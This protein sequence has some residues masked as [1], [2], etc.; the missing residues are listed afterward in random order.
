MS[1]V[2]RSNNE[3]NE[4]SWD[5]CTSD[6]L[7]ELVFLTVVEEIETGEGTGKQEKKK[8]EQKENQRQFLIRRT[9]VTNDEVED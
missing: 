7:P 1:Q 4:S 6:I 5:I 9:E 3:F 8:R 2:C